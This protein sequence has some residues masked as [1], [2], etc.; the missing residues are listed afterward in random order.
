MKVFISWSGDR[1]QR[2]AE[3]LKDWIKCVLQAVEPWVSTSGI[4][5][6]EVW[7]NSLSTQL[8]DTSI[9][10][11]CLTKENKNKPWILFEAGALAK[12]MSKT[13]VCTFLIDLEAREI[14]MPLAQF[15]HTEFKEEDIYRLVSTIN[16][17]LLDKALPLDILTKVFTTYWPQ[18][19][20]NYED[21]I[22]NVPEKTVEKTRSN[23]DVLDEI[24]YN[25]RDLRKRVLDLE[26]SKTEKIDYKI[27][28]KMVK[29]LTDEN[30]NKNKN[31]LLSNGLFMEAL[32]NMPF[33][34]NKNDRESS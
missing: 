15:N 3:L 8:N 34:K 14:E 26:K 2:V 20:T 24:L 23:E 28:D 22:N 31:E 27:S 7:F 17:E 11:I 10:I 30:H 32:K 33:P 21:I 5:S 12:E 19:K 18:F 29:Y 13:K 6:G 1:S 16:N 4:G 9:G 25:T